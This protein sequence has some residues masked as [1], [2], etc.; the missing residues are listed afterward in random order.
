M[1]ER[2]PPHDLA[3]ELAALGAVLI[4]NAALPT[5]TGLVKPADFYFAKH[6]LILQAMIDL[7]ATG[8]PIDQITIAGHLR[9]R[10]EYDRAG[11]ISTLSAITDGAS[12]SANAAHYARVIAEKAT[13][14]AVLVAAQEVAAKACDGYGKFDDFV[15]EARSKIT[16]AAGRLELG[17]DGPRGISDDLKAAYLDI[18][19]QRVPTGLVR[20][21]IDTIDRATGGLFPGLLTVLAGRPSMGKSCLGLNIGINVARQ[22]KR[23][24][25]VTMEDT[26]YFVVLRLLSRF[27]DCDLTALTL[28]TVHPDAYPRL[29][30]AITQLDGLPFYV[31][32]AS[33]LTPEQIHARAANLRETNGLDLVIIDHLMEVK[34][35]GE[36]DTARVS[37]AV[38]GIRDIV[39]ELNIPGLLL[40]QLNRGVEMRA[41]KRPTMADLKQTG[42]VEEVCRAAWFLYRPAYY[43][44]DDL[45]RRDI[46]L[47]VGKANHG[48]TGTVKLWGD[49]SRMYIRGWDRDSDGTFP[50]IDKGTQATGKW[51]SAA[52]TAAS[53]REEY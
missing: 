27:A 23:V 45:D 11:G 49:L 26:R 8:M 4:D 28:R 25:Y 30:H 47:I 36:S 14:R 24:L 37:N 16:L 19:E 1:A 3:A 12:T 29:L 48:R 33:R 39:K 9:D 34:A 53:H 21:G 5:I 44:G 52:S 10:G 35:E 7:R 40:H 41:D 20:T 13:V 15:S 31:D 42:R 2:V 51:T 17:R 6:G 18:S 46:Q 22:G 43:D 38:E 32:D 50:E